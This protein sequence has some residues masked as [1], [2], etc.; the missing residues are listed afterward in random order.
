MSWYRRLF[1]YF[2]QMYYWFV[3]LKIRYPI[4]GCLVLCCVL[5]L[6]LHT[7]ATSDGPTLPWPWPVNNS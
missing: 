1:A 4:L 6:L 2:L 5:A 7:N 3:S